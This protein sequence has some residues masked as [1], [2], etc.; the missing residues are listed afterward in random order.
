MH[1]QVNIE[2]VVLSSYLQ[3]D[4]T[5]D[6]SFKNNTRK[7]LDV[8]MFIIPFHKRIAERINKS[9]QIKEPLPFLFCTIQ[10]KIMG[11]G[12]ENDLLL[13]EAT[14]PLSLDCGLDWYINYLIQNKIEREF[15]HE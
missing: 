13:I 1:N 6:Y 10:D 15:A 14:I 9:I 8:D 3:I 4:L 5:T 11:T 2:R 12:Y 7:I